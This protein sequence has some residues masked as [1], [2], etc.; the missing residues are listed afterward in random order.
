M[1]TIPRINQVERLLGYSPDL[2]DTHALPQPF[3]R[4][5]HPQGSLEV[6]VPQL[7]IGSKNIT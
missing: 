6:E 2:H 1:F 4:V 5:L 7:V 3:D